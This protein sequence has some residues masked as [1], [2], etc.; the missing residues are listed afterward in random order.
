MELGR[1]PDEKQLFRLFA[2]EGDIG[3]AILA[4]PR[5]PAAPPCSAAATTSETRRRAV[6]RVS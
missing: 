1:T 5:L 4:P 2:N 6:L 3:K